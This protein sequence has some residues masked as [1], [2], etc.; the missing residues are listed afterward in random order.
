MTGTGYRR[1]GRNSST[2]R[3]GWI[4]L[5]AVLQCVGTAAATGV[6][7]DVPC[8]CEADGVCRPNRLEWGFYHTNW[9]RW[10]GDAPSAAETAEAEAEEQL[11]EELPGFQRPEAVDEDLR[12]PAKPDRDKDDDEAEEEAAPA[13]G[14]PAVL[15]LQGGVPVLSLPI[16][17]GVAAAPVT[18]TDG[19]G[20]AAPAIRPYMPAPL[21]LVDPFEA[22]P[23]PTTYHPAPVQP[24]VSAEPL[25]DIPP[26]LPPSLDASSTA[27]AS[28]VG[29]GSEPAGDATFASDAAVMPAGPP[30]QAFALVNPVAQRVVRAATVEP[31]GAIA[32]VDGNGPVQA[33]VWAGDD[34]GVQPAS[35]D[36]SAAGEDEASRGQ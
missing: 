4:A 30:R 11:K 19:V 29:Y 26:V 15:P 9:R 27:P 12:G 17:N 10:P 7:P 25:L 24:A 5:C 31:A 14:V 32:T 6:R 16:A 1:T 8:P 21:G 35:F 36:E 18:A 13:D 3:L 20:G 34:T 28:R 33:A 2:H 22:I 23:D